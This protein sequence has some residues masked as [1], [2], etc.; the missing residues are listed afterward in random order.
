MK[1]IFSRPIAAI[2]I[3][4]VALLSLS[5][6]SAVNVS[7]YIVGFG[8]NAHPRDL[9]PQ[10]RVL[11]SG[12]QYSSMIN[13]DGKFTFT[14]V[15]EGT[16]LLEVQ[17]SQYNY[18]TIKLSVAEKETKANLVG[19]G[20]DWS[21]NDN[22]LQLP[23]TIVPRAAITYFIPREGFKLSSLFANPMMLMMG[24]SVLMLFVMPKLMANMDPE[25]MEEMQGMQDDMQMPSF[26]MPD[27]S[28]TLA[29]FSTGGASSS[30]SPKAVSGKKKQ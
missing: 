17:S 25:A 13:K 21:N 2:T 23:L 15:P 14:N 9:S 16:Y 11:L 18:P 20:Y 28:A 8:E 3:A 29:K 19:L 30:S 5:T 7:G 26:E 4:V 27:I 22:P 6:V 1:S 24:A 12:G 10:T